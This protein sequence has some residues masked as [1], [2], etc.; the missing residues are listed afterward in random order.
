L[1]EPPEDPRSRFNRLFDEGYEQYRAGQ[2]AE[3]IA[4]WQEA[5]RLSP[6]NATIRVNLEIASAKLSAR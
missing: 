1:S 5:Q 2:L 6:D 3:A 4:T